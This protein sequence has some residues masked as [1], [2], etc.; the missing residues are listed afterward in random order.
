MQEI[1][2]SISFLC[3]QFPKLYSSRVFPQLF[4]SYEINDLAKCSG[5]F[6]LQN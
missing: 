5:F 2:M 6:S 4:D 1:R 3:F